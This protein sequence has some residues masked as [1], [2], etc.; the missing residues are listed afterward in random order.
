MTQSATVGFIGLG[1]LGSAMALRLK[2]SGF[3]VH[4]HDLDPGKTEIGRAHV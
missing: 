3:I 2:H 1:L 4:G